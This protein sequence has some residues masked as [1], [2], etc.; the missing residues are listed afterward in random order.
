MGWAAVL[1]GRSH[2]QAVAAQHSRHLPVEGF[3]QIQ[4]EI[5]QRLQSGGGVGRMGRRVGQQDSK[6]ARA[7]PWCARAAHVGCA[8]GTL[9]LLSRGQ[10][11][12]AAGGAA[13]GTQRQLHRTTRLPS[14]GVEGVVCSG[15]C[16]LPKH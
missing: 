1:P 2:E 3:E 13:W 16:C 6:A 10:H 8:K 12:A 7:R 14:T 15:A 11:L 9:L 4:L 5:G